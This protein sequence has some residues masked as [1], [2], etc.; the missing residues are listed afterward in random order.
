[1]VDPNGDYFAHYRTDQEN[2]AL[3]AETLLGNLLEITV[4]AAGKTNA[5][6]P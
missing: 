5:A 1:M 2:A 3:H 6:A 4:S